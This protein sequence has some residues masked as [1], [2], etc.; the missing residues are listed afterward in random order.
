MFLSDTGRKAAPLFVLRS[1]W[2]FVDN[3]DT[4][5]GLEAPSIT[6]WDSWEDRVWGCF[7]ISHKK[8]KKKPSFFSEDLL[9]QQKTCSNTNE[10]EAIILR[11]EKKKKKKTKK[12]K[13]FNNMIHS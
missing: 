8:K 10:L 12:K 2:W 9:G 3:L 13:P 4:S 11:V 5:G 1:F 6:R 7:Q